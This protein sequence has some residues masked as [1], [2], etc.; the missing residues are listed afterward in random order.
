MC[1]CVEIMTRTMGYV[2]HD[3]G[4]V[5]ARHETRRMQRRFHG[6]F[7]SGRQRRRHVL[8]RCS[9]RACWDDSR[10]TKV[11]NFQR[12]VRPEQHVGRLE[13]TMDDVCRV[14]EARAYEKLMQEIP[15]MIGCDPLRAIVEQS[16]HVKVHRFEDHV[17]LGEPR[18]GRRNHHAAH[19]HDIRMSA[20]MT[21]DAEFSEDT[22]RSNCT[23]EDVLNFFDRNF[24]R[25][26]TIRRDRDGSVRTLSGETLQ[27]ISRPDVPSTKL[28]H[29]QQSMSTFT[30]LVAGGWFG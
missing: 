7:L 28:K 18:G 5:S 29:V 17:D 13:I 3:V 25:V 12:T 26:P 22:F 11:T 1:V 21:K 14:Y 27:T 6:D 24:L 10:E 2:R 19:L 23:R 4:R 8:R 9:V 15:R 20:K 30:I 16:G